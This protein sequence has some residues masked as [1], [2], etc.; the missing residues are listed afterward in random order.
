MAR[1]ARHVEEPLAIPIEQGSG[2]VFA[3]LALEQPEELLVKA[4]LAHRISSIITHRRL[5]QQAAAEILDVDQ[6]KV[7]ALI[8]GR[9]DQ[10]SIER[11][12]RFLGAL[13]RDIDIVVRKKPRTT[14]RARLRVVGAAQD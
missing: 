4:D 13:G 9:L 11:L 8:R 14:R 3:D 12:F 2:N 7:S 5:T 10:F 1:K 6:P